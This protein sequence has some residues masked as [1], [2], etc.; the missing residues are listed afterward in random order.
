MYINDLL[1]II[2][3]YKPMLFGDDTRVLITASNLN[4]L[5]IRS[6]SILNHKSKWFA[7]NGLSLNI[8]KTNVIRFHFDHLVSDAFQILYQ[9]KEIKEVTYIKFLGL[10]LD[11]HVE[12]K[13]RI[14]QIIP[15]MSSA[16]KLDLCF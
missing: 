8:Y 10:G 11:K 1:G 6:T 13:T 4:D 3:C 7:M 12:W 16:M 15:K 9:D 5:Q 2:T 14:E